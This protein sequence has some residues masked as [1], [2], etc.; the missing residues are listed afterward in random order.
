M[1]KSVQGTSFSH[2][3]AIFISVYIPTINYPGAKGCARLSTMAEACHDLHP[4]LST[5]SCA[6]LATITEMVEHQGEEDTWEENL[7]LQ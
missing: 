4:V 6:V 7:G 1:T 2:I 5:I 3:H